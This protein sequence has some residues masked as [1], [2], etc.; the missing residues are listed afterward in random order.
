MKSLLAIKDDR[1]IEIPYE[2]S[3]AFSQ[4][5]GYDVIEFDNDTVNEYLLTGSDHIT[6][7]SDVDS[8][9]VVKMTDVN[10]VIEG[11]TLRNHSNKLFYNGTLTRETCIKLT[12]GDEL[13]IGR[14]KFIWN[15]DHISR[16]Y[17]RTSYQW[18]EC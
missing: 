2:R 16:P 7:S 17:P 5:N 12:D 8:D 4:D 11:D 13:I 10:I 15:K 14:N 1:Y 18:E 6:I 3:K 9:I